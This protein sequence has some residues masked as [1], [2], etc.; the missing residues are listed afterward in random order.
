VIRIVTAFRGA[1]ALALLT[2]FL[3]QT[4]GAA[5][6]DQA[7]GEADLAAVKTYLVDHGAA[8]KAGTAALRDTAER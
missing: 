7:A 2:G 3:L 6:Q 5:A 4:V 1:L 8:M